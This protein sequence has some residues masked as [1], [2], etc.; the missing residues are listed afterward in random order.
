MEQKGEFTAFIAKQ[1]REHEAMLARQQ[2]QQETHAII[3][4]ILKDRGNLPPISDKTA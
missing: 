4:H 3:A 1:R 2:D